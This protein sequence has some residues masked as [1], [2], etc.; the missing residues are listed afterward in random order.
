MVEGSRLYFS[1]ESVRKLRMQHSFCTEIAVFAYTS[2]FRLDLP[3][4]CI[5]HKNGHSIIKVAVR[6]TTDKS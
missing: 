2:R 6:G 1:S 5:N 4:C 3:K